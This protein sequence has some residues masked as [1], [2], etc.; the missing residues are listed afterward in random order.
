MACVEITDDM[1]KYLDG[2]ENDP[3][4]KLYPPEIWLSFEFCG[5]TFEQCQCVVKQWKDLKEKDESNT[6]EG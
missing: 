3:Q 5:L 2:M 1:I 6:G 4:G